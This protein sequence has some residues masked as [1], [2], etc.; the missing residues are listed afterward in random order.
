MK[1]MAMGRRWLGDGEIASKPKV[2]YLLTKGDLA[3][4]PAVEERRRAFYQTCGE[5]KAL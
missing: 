3:T 1:H 4:L 5:I 2:S